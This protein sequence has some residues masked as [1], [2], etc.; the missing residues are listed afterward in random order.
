M[1]IFDP[2]LVE[3]LHQ[4]VR[5]PFHRIGSWLSLRRAQPTGFDAMEKQVGGAATRTPNRWPLS[6]TLFSWNEHEHFRLADAVCGIQA[7][8]ATG[9]GKTAGLMAT[10]IKSY[11]HHGFGICCLTVKPEDAQAYL[12]Y[13]K[14]A[15]RLDDVILLGP[16]HPATFNFMKE[17]AQGG[18][19]MVG[20]LTALIT[21][22]SGMAL[23][24]GEHSD[25]EGGSFWIKMDQ[26]LITACAQLL[27]L[28]GEP[29]TT[30]NLERLVTSM[31]TSREQV[32]DPVWAGRSYLH[33]CLQM[34]EARIVSPDDR[35]DVQRLA[36]YFLLSMAELSEKTRSTVQT[37]VTST[38]DLFNGRVAR[39]LLS[40]S[41]PT[42]EMSMLQEGKI[43]LVDMPCM[44][45][46]S[47]ARLI[48]MVLKFCF[49]LSQ[50][51]RDVN[52][53]PRPAALV[54]DESQVLVDLEHDA[55]FLCTARSTR[56][57]VVYA[58]Q[59]LSNYLSES[60]GPQIEPRVHA[61]I[62]NLQCQ[63]FCQSTDTK[64]VEYC[65]NLLGK[66]KTLFMNV[67][68]QSQNDQWVASALGLGNPAGTNAGFSEHVD[69]LVQADDLHNLA[70][71]GPP[72]WI[73]EALIYQGG[74]TFASTGKPYLPVRFHQ[75]PNSA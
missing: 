36:D 21:A 20:N 59:S 45:H 13:A 22:I 38:L 41:E 56:T 46:G 53:N 5:Q 4:T 54:L 58:T 24:G 7:W 32:G 10:T 30:I 60:G 57:C 6:K 66:R 73:I 61:M 74:K 48:Q 29:V 11:M 39:R 2:K 33:C 72:D 9:S 70:K 40:S 19:G 16:S 8:G 71:G 37:S 68:T 14:D 47:V 43:L 67:N 15:G 27:V 62:S 55:Q 49:Q 42:F 75:R 69:H 63:V 18:A 26:R 64:T 3:Q 23:G 1:R 51:R 50:N 52:L 44:V 25:R 34:A 65:Q 12:A 35:E 17:V 28:A 31:P